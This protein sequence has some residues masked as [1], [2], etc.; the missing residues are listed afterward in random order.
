MQK[1]TSKSKTEEGNVIIGKTITVSDV[2]GCNGG[3]GSMLLVLMMI[4]KSLV[5]KSSSKDCWVGS[6]RQANWNIIGQKILYKTQEM[7][8]GERV[9][10]SLH[11][12]KEKEKYG[13]VSL[14]NQQI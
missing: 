3:W 2:G 12:E 1:H 11:I 10:E 14:V 9:G 7:L 6:W 8:E 5:A 13:I 4:F